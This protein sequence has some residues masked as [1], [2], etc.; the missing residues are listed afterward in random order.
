[1]KDED[2]TSVLQNLLDRHARDEVRIA[3]LKAL[4]HGFEDSEATPRRG[5]P[6]SELRKLT[7]VSDEE[8][9]SA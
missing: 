3:K 6:K 7:V 2:L 8:A 5:R 1:M 9:S 4:L